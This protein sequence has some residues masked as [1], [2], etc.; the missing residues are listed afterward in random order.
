M[1]L[2]TGFSSTT[3]LGLKIPSVHSRYA[4]YRLTTKIRIA[5]G[6]EVATEYIPDGVIVEINGHTTNFPLPTIFMDGPK[7]VGC[8]FL[9]Q[10]K[11]TLDGPGNTGELEF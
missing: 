2:D 5:N 8:M 10:C 7:V 4:Y 3:G 6:N 1:I 11:L 9:Q